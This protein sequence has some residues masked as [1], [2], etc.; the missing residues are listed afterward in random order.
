MS[1]LALALLVTS[2]ALLFIAFYLP[3]K[4]VR[5]IHR[6]HV[7]GQLFTAQWRDEIC[8]ALWHVV[9]PGLWDCKASRD[10][11]TVHQ[12]FRAVHRRRYIWYKWFEEKIKWCCI[13]LY[14]LSRVRSCLFYSEKVYFG[15]TKVTVIS[16]AQTRSFS[17]CGSWNGERWWGILSNL[18]TSADSKT[19]ESRFLWGHTI[20]G[21]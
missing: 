20:S 3:F 15:K 13:Y 16:A 17:I 18:D 7:L 2:P 12:S 8:F 10:T 6:R 1:F 14:V 4:C 11:V 9:L 21:V 19:M 5:V